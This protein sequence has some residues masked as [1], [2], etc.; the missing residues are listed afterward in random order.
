MSDV[1]KFQR[2]TS[3]TVRSAVPGRYPLI[4]NSPEPIGTHREFNREGKFIVVARSGAGAGTVS[5]WEGPLF[6][7]DAF[8][9]HPDLN[10][11]TARFVYY[12]LQNQQNSIHD[13][14]AGSGV[15]HVRVRDLEEYRIPVPPLAEQER[16]VSILD[17]FDML[18]NDLSIG[19]PAELSARRK[20]YEYYRDK[21]LNFKELEPAS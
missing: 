14:K 9:I 6:L 12:L 2:G 17:K 7:T 21:L 19:L 15:P 18:L 3:I 20:Q 11:V 4:A 16:L 8:S 13:M 10:L 1:A 5:F